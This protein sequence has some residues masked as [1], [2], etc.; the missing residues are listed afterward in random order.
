[1]LRTFTCVQFLSQIIFFCFSFDCFCCRS[2]CLQ[3]S[4]YVTATWLCGHIDRES[5]LKQIVALSQPFCLLAL[6]LIS[7]SN[8]LLQCS[9]QNFYKTELNKEEMYIRYIHKLYDL[10]LKAQNYT[11]TSPRS[12]PQ[13]AS[14]CGRDISQHSGYSAHIWECVSMLC[15]NLMCVSA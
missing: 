15:C 11:G 4:S 8:S 14:V 5:L 1:M 2:L 3:G 13:P 10:H 9:P 12:D 7:V 6:A